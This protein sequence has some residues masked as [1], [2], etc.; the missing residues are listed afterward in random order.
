MKIASNAAI[1]RAAFALLAV[2]FAIRTD[3]AQNNSDS[4][5]P[6]ILLI[7]SDD[8]GLD[9]VTDMY[10][11]LV[12]DLLQKYGPQGLNH[13]NYQAIKGHPASTP[14]LDQIA[15]QGM[16]F[17]NTWAQP[18]C[19][20]T[21]S[22]ILTGL[23]SV[24][25]KVLTYADPL[26]LTHTSL[27]QKLRDDGA[28]STA[29]FGKWHMA[30]LPANPVNYPGMKPKQA[31]FD[32]FKGNMHAALK[33]YWDYDYQ[34]QD[35]QSPADQWRTEAAPKKSLPG[36]APTTYAPVVNAADTIEWITAQEKANPN[37][38]WFVWL[39]FN[40]AHA[41]QQQQPSAMAIPEAA[42][43][44]DVSRK[45][46][47]A[48]GGSFGSMNTGRCSGE[49]L[50]R[51]M[52]NSLDTI[53]G[54]VLAAVDAVDPNTYVIYVGDNGTPMYGRPNLD[55]IDNMYLTKKGRGKGT[56]YESGTRVPMAIRGPGITPASRSSEFVHV[57]DLFSTGLELAGLKPPQTVSNSAGTGTETVD[58][59][60]LTPILLNKAPSVRNPDQD[61]LISETIDLQR[62]GAREVGARNR[63][64]KL[65][66]KETA[67]NCE[68]FNVTK[69][70]L[71]EFPLAK[72][73]NC[74]DYKSGA[75]KRT[76]PAWH[77]CRLNEVV[78]TKS[79]F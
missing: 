55:F 46:V 10:P 40:L 23:F 17:T 7:I 14:V 62:R 51:V 74:T 58:S 15:R 56:T 47:E 60:S 8:I 53:L 12:D 36:I 21:R 30:G 69:D 42:T 24:K 2:F 11:G 54:K 33:T 5:R 48:C 4:R 20:P 45:E 75:L 63:E 71:E 6:N 32:L 1:G 50:M 59:V 44:D 65:V 34:V 68:F 57:V 38:P 52:T 70:P 39:A 22:S 27:A 9:V 78:R 31:G 3:A 61:F 35:S 16:V 19:S 67:D 25:T 76:D 28:Y 72:P 13:P 73:D 64:Y 37:K 66:C 43:L 41:T 18:F 49:T 79:F 29:V 26:A 77:F